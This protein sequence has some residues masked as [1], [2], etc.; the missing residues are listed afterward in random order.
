M[1]GGKILAVAEN[2]PQRLRHRPGRRLPSNQILV[3]AVTFERGMQ[4]LA[5]RRVAV[6]VAQ[7]R[8][9]FDR[10][11]LD[12]GSFGHALPSLD[13]ARCVSPYGADWGNSRPHLCATGR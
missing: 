7:E 8:A 13:A 9:V 6:A 3:D 4:P 10:S 1:A 5:P 11:S 2:R 12:R